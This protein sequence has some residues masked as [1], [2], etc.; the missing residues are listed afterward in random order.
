MV[1]KAQREMEDSI[2]GLLTEEEFTNYLLRM[3]STANTMRTQIAGFDP[4][5]E[6]FME[7]FE[8]RRQFDNE[9]GS[10]F[11]NPNSS[12]TDRDAYNAAKDVMNEQ[13]REAL[14]DER[15]ADYDRAQDYSIEMKQADLGSQLSFDIRSGG[16]VRTARQFRS[17]TVCCRKSGRKPRPPSN[18]PSA[19]KAGKNTTNKTPTGRKTPHRTPSPA[20]VV[21]IPGP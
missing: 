14:G 7:V 21:E 13:I 1:T 8:L 20:N 10:S 19:A 5:K 6:E 12:D 4:S 15:Y 9:Y 2:K 11:F 17:A 3:S 18:R 16:D